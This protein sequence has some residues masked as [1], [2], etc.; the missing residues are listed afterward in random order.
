M[1]ETLNAKACNELMKKA[2]TEG[3]RKIVRVEEK[4]GYLFGYDKD[5]KF[6]M[7]LGKKT[8]QKIIKF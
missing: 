5:G 3:E 2:F 6:V 8:L 7:G 1:D 4:E